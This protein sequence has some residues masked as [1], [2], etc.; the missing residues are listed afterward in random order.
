MSIKLQKI[1]TL[2]KSVDRIDTL[3]HTYIHELRTR[4][5]GIP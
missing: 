4:T 3:P 1:D 2:K 5:N